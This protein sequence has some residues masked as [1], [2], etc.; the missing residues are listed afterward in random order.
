MGS[1]LFSNTTNLLG[2]HDF[3]NPVHRRKVA[4]VLEIDEARIPREPSWPYHRIIEGVLRALAVPFATRYS[5]SV[6]TTLFEMG[7]AALEACDEIAA[8]TL[9]MPNL[10]CLRIDL[11]PFGRQN[12][13]V[14]FVPTDEPHG[15]IE[16]TI[17]RD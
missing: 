3:A 13:N 2:G 6:Q 17:I 1:R 5:P 8:I 10:H 16:A 14:L 7:S 11:S 15:Q 4:D 12:D 9:A